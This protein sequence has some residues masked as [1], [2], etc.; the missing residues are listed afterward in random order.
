MKNTMKFTLFLLILSSLG[1]AYGEEQENEALLKYETCSESTSIP[2]CQVTS[3]IPGWYRNQEMMTDQNGNPAIDSGCREK[4]IQCKYKETRSEGW[5]VSPNYVLYQ[6]VNA[7]EYCIGKENRSCFIQEGEEFYFT[8]DSYLVLRSHFFDIDVNDHVISKEEYQKRK[9]TLDQI[10]QYPTPEFVL[11]G[12]GK[13]AASVVGGIIGGAI[14]GGAAGGPPGAVAG[15][16][17]G[18]LIG[19]AASSDC[20]DPTDPVISKP[21]KKEKRPD[22][23]PG[24]IIDM[25]F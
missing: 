11:F 9:E 6:E 19:W 13:C 16:I 17:G 22:Y 10:I 21:K 12:W 4:T 18:G 24:N 5:Y 1:N 25:N 23:I 2:Y 3:G 8:E 14:S 7:V 15:G 20:P